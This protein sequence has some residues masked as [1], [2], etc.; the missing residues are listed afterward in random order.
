MRR[1]TNRTVGFVLT[2]HE[3][4]VP[5]DHHNPGNGKLSVFAREVISPKRE[6]ER[7]E[8]PWLVFFQGGPGSEAPRPLRYEGWLKRAVQEFR[9]LLLDQRGTGRSTPV[10]HQTLGGM[11]PVEQHAHLKHFRADSIIRDAELIRREL[12]AEPWT[13]LGQSFG[14]FCAVSYLSLAPAGLSAAVITGGLPPL[15]RPVDDVYRA[16]YKRLADRNRRYYERYPQDVERV[17]QII[18]ILAKDEVKLSSGE[19]LTP[20]RFRTLGIHFGMSDGFEK[21]HYLVEGALL[22]SGEIDYRFLRAFEHALIWDTNPIYALLHEPCYAQGAAP[23]WSADRVLAEF[24]EF[25]K[26][27]SVYFWGEMVYP[28]LF[29]DVR[30]LR[31]LKG[32]ADRLAADA[33][34]PK[35]YD[36]EALTRNVVPVVA[37]IYADDMYVEREFSEETA[38]SIRGIH[39]WLTNEYDHNALRV[40]GEVLLDRLLELLRGER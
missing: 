10:T 20:R 23:G 31:P 26:D 8:L 13:I 18:K 24:P 6:H 22:P 15:E 40:H 34:W 21:V 12:G 29:D 7:E 11:T 2:E 25:T 39:T 5:L 14:G 32:A 4:D 1:T 16:T 17:R 28:W 33:D 9:V 30:V 27:D 3:F 35:L 19:R 37:A 38:A 36:R